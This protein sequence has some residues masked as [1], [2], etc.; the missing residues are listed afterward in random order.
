M[1]FISLL[2]YITAIYIRPQEWLPQVYGWP[3]IDILAIATAFFVILETMHTKKIIVNHPQ[4]ILLLAFLG[5]VVFS[6]LSHTY[7]WGAYD[8]FIKFGKIVVMF[9]L[10]VT[11]LN[12]QKKLKIAIWL[13]VIL[14]VILAL[15]GIYQYRHGFGWAG[16]PLVQ[17]RGKHPIFR[18]TWI[19][20]FNDPNDLALAFVVA[21]GFLLSFIFS[22]VSFFTK[23]ISIPLVGV[24]IYS[25]YLTN[26]RGGYLALGATT[27]Y[28]FLRKMKN[29]I[30]A[31]II[32]GVL[33][34]SIFIFG[35]SRL[36]NISIREDSAYGRIEAWYE[37][38][39][40]LKN[41]PLFGVGYRMF[42]DYYP[43]T[44]H[45]SYILVAAEE[46]LIGLFIWIALIYT[47]FKG[48]YILTGRN[49]G[50]K[51]YVSGLEAGL[52]G[53]LSASFFLSRSYVTLLYILLAL[54]SAF[55]YTFL[56][57]EEYF[58]GK[59]MRRAGI[60]TIGILFI[61]WISMRVSLRI[62]G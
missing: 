1:S 25:L 48:L 55:A 62:L 59:E 20:I 38:F 11:V 34:F 39:Q 15:Q 19:G 33:A 45:N 16:Q 7:M 51:P 44:A 54:A 46:G 42:T 37:G 49:N 22:R 12:S 26:S 10:F 5:A 61:L 60:L 56:K 28:Y 17:Q 21:I 8:S 24:L 23:I 31:L 40:M 27:M 6:H 53:F 35:P 9:F 52:V 2:L 47:C 32:G 29:K 14:T 4:N 3:L 57:K 58:G 36:S 18:I 41:A 43:L 30:L 13:I 50:L